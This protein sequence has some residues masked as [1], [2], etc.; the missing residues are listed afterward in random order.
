MMIMKD[1]LVLQDTVQC[2]Q[3]LIYNII[4]TLLYYKRTVLLYTVYNIHVYSV[5]CT[6][7]I[8]T[9]YEYITGGLFRIH[10]L[11]ICIIVF[12]KCVYFIFTH[13]PL[14]LFIS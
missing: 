7:Y 1:L 11:I 8:Y 6:M 5:Q 3:I 14:Y 9:Y 2:L 10:L 4:N 13:L 12:E